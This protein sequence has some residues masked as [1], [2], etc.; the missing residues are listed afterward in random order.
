MWGSEILLG[1]C[2][3]TR[4]SWGQTLLTAPKEASWVLLSPSRCGGPSSCFPISNG[5]G[6]GDQAGVAAGTMAF[7]SH[8]PKLCGVRQRIWGEGNV[9]PH[10]CG[11]KM[12]LLAQSVARSTKRCSL[13]LQLHC[14]LLGLLLVL[15]LRNEM[16]FPAL[17]SKRKAN[18]SRGSPHHG[19]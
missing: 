19:A 3:V 12:T 14:H 10:H 8:P 9:S 2:L 13:S 18:S 17:L 15:S 7:A 1:L 16:F 5:G 4:W 6:R 11:M